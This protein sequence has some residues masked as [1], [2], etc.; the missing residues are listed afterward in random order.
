MKKK[1]ASFFRALAVIWLVA[2]GVLLF[3]GFLMIWWDDDFWTAAGMFAPWRVTNW[4]VILASLSP[5]FLFY[6]IADKLHPKFRP[7]PQ[8]IKNQMERE[9]E[10][11]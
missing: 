1:F 9:T 2:V 5:G 7:I 6:W 4:L 3:T 10:D 8:W 11:E